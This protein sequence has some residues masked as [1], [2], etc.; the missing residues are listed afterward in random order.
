MKNTYSAN[1]IVA[2]DAPTIENTSKDIS[3]IE[4]G[5]LQIQKVA[6]KPHGLAITFEYKNTIYS[7]EIPIFGLHHAHN[8]VLAFAMAVE[9]GI[10]TDDIQDALATMPQIEHRLE[11]VRNS[12]GSI[13]IDDA[14]NS[15]PIGFQ[16][17]LTLLATLRERGRKILITPGMVELGVAHDDAHEKIGHSAG[18]ICDICLVVKPDRIPTF[19]KGFKSTGSGKT[20][21]EFESFKEA[22]AWYIKN[23]QPDDVLL[24]EN[25]LPDMYERIPKM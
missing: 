18:E 22:Q 20:L 24:I 19:I 13:L 15:N 11:V 6:Q 14:Y 5:D 4:K 2:G 25:D 16:S 17:A 21:M 9:L 1:F 8:V 12:D 7:P 3:Y 10:S 23:K